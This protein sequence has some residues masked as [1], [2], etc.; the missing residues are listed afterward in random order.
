[1]LL[2]NVLNIGAG[3]K[4]LWLIFWRNF[5]LFYGQMLSSACEMC[6]VYLHVANMKS[7]KL[8]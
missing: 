4:E 6:L 8:N 3:L 2:V 5:F 1:V 7:H